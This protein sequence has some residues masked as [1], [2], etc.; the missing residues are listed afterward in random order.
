MIPQAIAQGAVLFQVHFLAVVANHPVD[1]EIV[2]VDARL[3]GQL[4]DDERVAVVRF[5]DEFAAEGKMERFDV[6]KP[7]LTMG[8]GEIPYASAAE[9]LSMDEGALRVAVHRLRKRYR[10]VLR[11][12]IAH[13]LSDPAMVEEEMAVLLGAFG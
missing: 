3:K 1:Q 8:K 10:E 4:A 13:T 5:G 12:E 11:E 7:F 9:A 2:R 6:M